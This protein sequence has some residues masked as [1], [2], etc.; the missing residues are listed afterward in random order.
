MKARLLGGLAVLA[1]VML[2]AVPA[3]A[4]EDVVVRS[5][6][7]AAVDAAHAGDTV[8]VPPGR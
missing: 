1:L 5:S 8:V 2:V 4:A 7:Q 3:A 6:I